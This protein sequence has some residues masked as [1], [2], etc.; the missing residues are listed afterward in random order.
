MDIRKVDLNLLV[1]FEAMIKHRSVTKGS[2]AIGLSQPAMSAAVARLRKL[3]D[4]PL[5]VQSGSTMQPTPRAVELAL[6]IH[7]VMN[8]VQFE[9]LQPS[10]FDPG[11]SMRTFTI[12]TPDIG[13][14]MFLPLLL[15]RVAKEAPFASLKTTS[16]T[17]SATALALEEGDAELAVGYFPDLQKTGFFQQKLFANDVV[18]IARSD[19]PKIRSP[20]TLENYLAASHAVIRPEGRE[21]V[22]EQFAKEYGLQRRI[23]VEVA[24]FMSLL[25]ILTMSDLIATVP[26]DLADVCARHGAIKILNLPIKAPCIEIYQYWHQRFQHDAANIW[27][28]S[29]IHELFRG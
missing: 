13:E 21:H 22:F 19:H 23:V 4:D 3:F 8:T 9:I 28:R 6:P 17:R 27:L 24:H 18:C 7:R 2:E 1:V 15:G 29:V 20:L 12:L 25:P 14:I 10:A 16:M 11:T 26:R 5:F